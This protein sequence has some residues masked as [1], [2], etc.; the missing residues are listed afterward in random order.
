[1]IGGIFD[2]LIVVGVLL[3]LLWAGWYAVKKFWPAAADSGAGQVIEKVTDTTQDY[4]AKAALQAMRWTDEVEGD[5]KVL[6]AWGVL[7]GAFTGV[8]PESPV[9][10]ASGQTTNPVATVTADL[11]PSPTAEQTG[12][13]ESVDF[14]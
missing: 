4:A 14:Q 7:Y 8:T 2:I 1:M 6:E 12:G 10:L 9:L 3:L 13:I 11:R 5:P